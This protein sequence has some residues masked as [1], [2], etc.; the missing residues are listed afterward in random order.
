MEKAGHD[1]PTIE[2]KGLSK[3]FGKVKALKDVHLTIEPGV[4]ALLGPNGAGKTTLLRILATVLQPDS[5]EI[6]VAGHPLPQEKESVRRL[7]GYLPQEFGVYREMTG[8]Q[9]LD[10]VGLLKGLTDNTFRHRRIEELLER[11][12]LK[13]VAHRKAATYSGGLRKRLGIAQ[14]LLGDP[15][16]LIVDEPTASLDPEAR[17]G[18]LNLLAQLGRNRVVL[19]STHI[20]GDVAAVAQMVAVLREGRVAFAGSLK[21]LQKQARGHVWQLELP[22]FVWE[23]LESRMRTVTVRQNG[24]MVEARVVAPH[25]PH[26]R[27]IPVEPRLEDAYIWLMGRGDG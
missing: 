2:V 14:A 7:M 21:D 1:V 26:E 19:L 27:A 13:A 16:V 22:L 10:Y 25:P 23:K 9:F 11:L 17:L 20:V 8:R 24:A 3:R 18:L 4:F 6:K 5:G 15:A 12:D